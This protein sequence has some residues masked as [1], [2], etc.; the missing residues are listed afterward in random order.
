MDEQKDLDEIVFKRKL[1]G[2]EIEIVLYDIEQKKAEKVVEQAYKEALRLQKIFNFYDPESELSKLNAKRELKVSQELLEVLNKAMVLSEQINGSYDVSMGKAILQRK[3]G[4]KITDKSSYKDV[5]I[6][7]NKVSLTNEALIDLGSIA[8]GFI[9]DKIGDF[10]KSKGV[11]KFLIDSRGDI[12]VSG[13]I[14]HVIPI[15]HPR[16]KDKIIGSITIYNEGVAT[17]GDYNQFYGD[18]DRSHILNKK[19]IISVTVIAPTLDEADAYA[20]ALMVATKE[21]RERLLNENN[22]IKV[23]LIEENLNKKSYNGFESEK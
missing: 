22:E 1:F 5:K 14:K 3:N 23:L 17:S 19:E 20:T 16:K 2:G 13:D 4:Q 15:Q 7:G 12:L 11:D 18:F 21:D 10:I 9:T 6:E 8:K